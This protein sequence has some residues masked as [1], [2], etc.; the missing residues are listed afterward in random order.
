MW[1]DLNKFD[2]NRFT[3]TNR[4]RFSPP[5]SAEQIDW[6]RENIYQPHGLYPDDLADLLSASATGGKT[7]T[8]ADLNPQVGSFTIHIKGLPNESGE[9]WWQQRKLDLSGPLFEAQAMYL[10]LQDQKKRMGRL[11]MADLVDTAARLGIRRITLEA[12]D[13]GR[14]AWARFGFVPDRTAWVGQVR[15]EARRRLLRARGD[16]KPHR[17]AACSEVLDGANP[18]LIRTVASWR[19]LVTSLTEIDRIAGDYKKIPLGQALLLEHGAQW[20]GEFNLDDPETMIIF[21]E[22]IGRAT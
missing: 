22:Y 4:L 9:V 15:V 2:R 19:D 10:P 1:N 12:Q 8:L 21:N 11:L 6:W 3:D 18:K 16:L 5:L 13:V 17:F 7:I 14:Y 20:F